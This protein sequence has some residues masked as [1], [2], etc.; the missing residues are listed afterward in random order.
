MYV[1]I[2]ATG[3]QAFVSKTDIQAGSKI[4]TLSEPNTG[5]PIWNGDRRTFDESQVTEIPKP[6][7]LGIKPMKIEFDE[8]TTVIVQGE[9][10]LLKAME[11]GIKNVR[12]G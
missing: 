9:I 11:N 1:K 3:I 5:Q 12:I 2:K 6:E 10:E 8:M 4:Y 7:N